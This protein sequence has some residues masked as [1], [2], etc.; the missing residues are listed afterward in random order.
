MMVVLVNEGNELEIGEPAPLFDSDH[1][2][3]AAGL[4]NYDVSADGQRFI[5]LRGVG[6]PREIRVIL[7]WL[8]E[9]KREVPSS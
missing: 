1:D 8:D 4:T 9:L 6:R 7:N 2:T 5:M 3:G